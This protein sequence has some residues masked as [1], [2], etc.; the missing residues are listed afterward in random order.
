MALESLAMVLGLLGNETRTANSPDAPAVA[1][2]FQPDIVLCDI[3]MPGMSGYEVAQRLRAD[4]TQRRALL[5]A[6]TG[7]GSDEDR[8]KAL[9][10]G[11]DRHL[12]KPVESAELQAL[13]AAPPGSGVR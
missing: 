1:R 5:V 13:L 10:A 2:A 12:T 11:F 8:R 4:A 7:W 9:Q 3:G 6:L